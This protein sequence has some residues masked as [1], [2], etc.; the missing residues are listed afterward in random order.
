MGCLTRGFVSQ[1][2][3]LLVY[4]YCWFLVVHIALVTAPE[5]DIYPAWDSIDSAMEN[6]ELARDG[7]RTVFPK[8]RVDAW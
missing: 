6:M 5:E 8:P 4:F 7:V 1:V 3:A 2:L